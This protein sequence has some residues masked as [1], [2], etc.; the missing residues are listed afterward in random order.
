MN[1]MKK[2]QKGFTLVELLVVVN[3]V[4]ILFGAPSIVLREYR[5]ESRCLRIYEALPQI[6]RSQ[7]FYCMQQNR[8]YAADH[9]ELRNHGVDVS[10]VGYFTYSTFPNEFSSYSVRADAAGGWVLY[11]H[12]GSP[13][14]SCDDALIKG[15]WLPEESSRH[16]KTSARTSKE[17][18]ATLIC[19][20]CLVG[21][22]GCEK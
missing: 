2:Y 3:I 10:E 16:K 19:S 12:R 9:N 14:W 21:T 4:A 20:R 13:T 7:A 11:T 6:V 5:S 18:L 22:M 17:E 8:C 15:I 1:M